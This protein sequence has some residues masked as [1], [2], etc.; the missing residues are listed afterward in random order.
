NGLTVILRENHQANVVAFHMWV[1]VGSA[2]ETDDI[3]GISHVYEHMLFKG[4]KKR[5]V[6][7]IAGE[8]EA[9]GGDI[10]AFTSLDQTVYH[11][12]IASEFF[13]KG[14]DIMADAIQNSSFDAEELKKEQEVIVEEIKR[15][16]DMPGRKLNEE[17]F[18]E[19]YTKHTYG[20]SVIGTPETVRGLTR[21]RI[22]GYFDKWYRPNNMTL[23]IVGD[24]NR[25]SAL[26]Q[27]TELF[28]D[29]PKGDAVISARPVE[30]EQKE[31]R[32]ISMKEKISETHMNFGYHIPSVR[33][34]DNATLDILALILGQ[35]ESSR[36]YSSIK[37]KKSLVHSIYSYAFTPKDPGIMM[38]GSMLEEKNIDETIRES[39]KEVDRLKYELVSQEE[40]AKAKLNLESDF[41]YE[42]ETMQGQAR[43]LGY[44]ATT[45]NDYLFETK[46]LERIRAVTAEDIRRV[47]N[48]YIDADKL[49]IAVLL[50]EKSE[51]SETKE[52]IYKKVK[53]GEALAKE[54]YGA[55]A[56]KEPVAS[57]KKEEIK[58]SSSAA[59]DDSDESTEIK[60]SK[61][62]LDNGITIIVKESHANPTFSLRTIFLG[63]VRYEDESNNGINNFIAGMLSKGSKN[64]SAAKMADEIESMAS[65]LDGYS[66]KNSIGTSGTFL[67]RFTKEALEIT[68]DMTLNPIFLQ[69]EIDKRKKHVVASI[70]RQEDELTSL[71]FN[72]FKSTHYK[73]SPYRFNALG[74]KENVESFTKEG[75]EAYHKKYFAPENLVISIVGDVDTDEIKG[76]VEKHFG[77]MN[78][79]S[80]VTP[81]VEVEPLHTEIVKAHIE[82]DKEQ[83]HIVLGFTGVSIRDADRVPL[84]VMTNVLSRQGGRLF[85]ELRDKKSLA[86]S[87]TAFSQEGYDPGTIIVYI[88][89]SPEKKDT[90]VE[91]I[92]TELKKIINEK[93]GEEE[94]SMAKNY[95]IGNHEIN[96]QRNSAQA[97]SI[98]FDEIYGLGYNDYKGYAGRVS[99]V[100]SDDIMRVA[101]K[102]LNL[103]GYT[104]SMV[105]KSSEKK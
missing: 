15:S 75:L 47:A 67:S 89:T 12:T 73:K 62:V 29:F 2:D 50:P 30:P 95:L 93:V 70:K 74:T 87:V 18:R 56:S 52:D 1:K 65:S 90:A 46:Y 94:L 6:G 37:S 84:E 59:V 69:E 86:Y 10:N 32:F 9:S 23:V 64:R 40:I 96:L 36:L 85:L 101:K 77:G 45:L 42:K 21:E 8:I 97:A 38:L 63:G 35:G 81:K 27:V 102:Y 58:T 80:F 103:E 33:H 92:L 83:T 68:A 104:L 71:A 57:A 98:G 31:F 5:G 14:L 34:E 20:R 16:R 4:T 91:G 3:S 53:A 24:F 88:A 54:A 19:V 26:K 13:D 25:D 44:F 7:E 99:A 49:T 66:G 79:G 22:V 82:K 78:K 51:F 11:I 55:A 105:G 43:K 76:L 60:E 48:Q 17:F 39:I 41:I 61:I 100:S 28:K 72:Q